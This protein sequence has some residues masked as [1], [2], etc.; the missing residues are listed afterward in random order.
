ML[1]REVKNE[2]A[3][4]VCGGIGGERSGGTETECFAAGRAWEES[5]VRARQIINYLA[6]NFSKAKTEELKP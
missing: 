4:P 6:A 1:Y 5:V 2:V 3:E